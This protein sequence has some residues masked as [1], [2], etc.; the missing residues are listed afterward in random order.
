M[1]PSPRRR[2]A[3]ADGSSLVAFPSCPDSSTPRCHE[4]RN[5]IDDFALDL[6]SLLG[7]RSSVGRGGGVDRHPVAGAVGGAG[8]DVGGAADGGGVGGGVGGAGDGGRVGS[9]CRRP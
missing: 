6:Q 7:G 8:G 9:V 2:G 5:E 3:A 4:L 1:L